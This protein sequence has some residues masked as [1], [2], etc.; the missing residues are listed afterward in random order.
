MN[1]RSG[2]SDDWDALHASEQQLRAANQQLQAS[3]QQLR[4][5]EQ[6]LRAA[7]QQLRATNEQLQASEEKFRAIFEQA[8]VGMAQ[9]ESRTGDCVRINQR[10]A[11]IVGYT[12]EEM[13][14]LTFQ[15]ITHP[16]DLQ[17]E[18]DY[19]QRLRTGEIRNFSMEKRY[20]H[21]DGSI[22]WVNLTVSPMWGPGQE[23]DYHIAVVENITD[24]KRAEEALGESEGKLREARQMAHLGYWYWDVRT[25]DVEWSEEVYRIF[26]RDPKEFTPQIDSIMAL[27]PWPEDNQ[28]HTELIQKAMESHEQGAY[29][30]RFL[31]PDGS[32]GHYYSTFEGLYDG[33][34]HLIAIKG[35]VQDTTDRKRAEEAAV[36]LSKFPSENPSPVLRIG[37]DG[38]VVY[39]NAASSCLVQTW[40]CSV[41]SFL[42]TSKKAVVD[43]VLATGEPREIEEEVNG[44]VLALTF[45]P[46]KDMGYVN[47]YGLD[48]TERKRAEEAAVSLSKFPSENPSPVLRIGADGAVVYHNT[49]SS[50][51]VQTWEC[52]V[53]SFLPASKTTV[54]D[55]VLATGEPREIE[56]EVNG[57]VLAL[58]F[59]PVKDMGYVNIYGLDITERKR[60]EEASTE[61]VQQMN[62]LNDLIRRAS[63]S[64]SLDQVAQSALDGI[65]GLMNADLSM[66]FTRDGDRLLLRA[67]QGRIPEGRGVVAPVHQV[68]QCLCGA[69]VSEKRAIY[70]RD[71]RKD[72]RCTWRECKEAGLVSL[73]ALPLRTGEGIVGVLAVGSIV[74]CDFGQRATFL[75]AMSHGIAV[76]VQNAFLYEQLKDRATKLEREIAERVRAEEA[77]LVHQG[78]LRSLA[79]E[80]SLAEE[81]ERRRIAAGLHDHACQTLALS[82]MRIQEL[83]DLL[84]PEQLDEVIGIC[85]TLDETIGNVRDLIFDLSS[86]TL[87][88]F[89]LEA[90]L[91]ELLEDKLQTEHGIHCT[92]CDDGAAKPLAE[93]VRILLFQSVRELL[94]NVVK[95][96]QAQ[97][98]S[99]D[100]VRHDDSVRITIRDDGVGFDVDEVLSTSS[101]S[102]GFG[103]FNVAERLDYIGGSLDMHSQLGQGSRFTLVAHLCADERDCS[104]V[105]RPSQTT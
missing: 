89:G 60:A 47:I 102:R 15:Q 100:I 32:T 44:R 92:F 6:Q 87:Y 10:Y 22:V 85:G 28:R 31:R 84:A 11:D 86:P 39:H 18:L 69:A 54:V 5:H 8:A 99:L 61:R 66:L 41:G 73:A 14:R 16:D 93:D 9:V 19:M 35:T 95:H 67:E 101:R 78:R 34:D 80:L 7:N 88:K 33:E 58:T 56:E 2:S 36:S 4:A 71:I 20:C 21:K 72:P 65:C 98:V 45:A 59:A 48:I 97:E 70:S 82:K 83:G 17:A 55:A 53:G 62:V 90:A 25:G 104:D 13:E 40:G 79:S 1:E 37:A 38:A 76:G 81:R 29:E 49:A 27:S 3:E 96:A 57:R 52:S 74:E 91:E 94:I 43:A 77:L 51:L 12:R 30:Q 75:E 103:L 68:G 26:H 105:P 64:L 42:P 46:V 50:C 63:S 23:P 24:R